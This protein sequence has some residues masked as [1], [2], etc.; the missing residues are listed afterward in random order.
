MYASLMAAVRVSDTL[1]CIDIDVP[2]E[3]SGEIVKALAKQVVA[4]SLRNLERLPLENVLQDSAITNMTQAHGA[5]PKELTVPEIL[6]GLVGH[7]EGSPENHDQDP[8]A[9][10]DDYIVGGTGVVKA[11]DICLNRAERTREDNAPSPSGAGTSSRALQEG[12]FKKGKAKEKSK[13]WLDSARKIR[14]RLQPAL[15][16]EA[17]NGDANSF[18][19]SYFPNTRFLLRY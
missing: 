7:V 11:L 18:S 10:D 17:K 8:P 1:I 4:Y 9:P 16:K 5:E 13:N 2:T 12:Q 3:D 14:A 6:M 15:I 19:K